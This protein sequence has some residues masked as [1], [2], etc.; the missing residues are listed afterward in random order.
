MAIVM[1]RSAT[2]S[3]FSGK[4]RR[5]GFLM[6]HCWRKRL[7]LILYRPKINSEPSHSVFMT[8]NC[9]IRN[10]VPSSSITSSDL[11]LPNDVQCH[12]NCV[13]HHINHLIWMFRFQLFNRT[14]DHPVSRKELFQPWYSCLKNESQLEH[15]IDW[16]YVLI[17]SWIL[18]FM[19]WR[20]NACSIAVLLFRH[21]SPL[22]VSSPVMQVAQY[23]ISFN[24]HVQLQSEC[25]PSPTKPL[26]TLYARVAFS[27]PLAPRISL[28]TS[29]SSTATIHLC[30]NLILKI[31]PHTIFN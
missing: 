23:E 13:V 7:I 11:N 22:L 21:V 25:L 14:C 15:E 27:K 19:Y 24:L 26:I 6:L 10:T 17:S 1:V 16:S 8:S 29:G 9:W 4:Y 31:Y 30:N 28:T 5:S 2:Y 20:W 18:P 3:E 12:A